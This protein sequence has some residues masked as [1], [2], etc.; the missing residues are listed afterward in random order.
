MENSEVKNSLDRLSQEIEKEFDTV[1]LRKM[2]AKKTSGLFRTIYPIE[3]SNLTGKENNVFGPSFP[4]LKS[5]NDN[6][7]TYACLVLVAVNDQGFIYNRNLQ[8][9]KSSFNDV[10]NFCSKDLGLKVYDGGQIK[11]SYAMSSG[12]DTNDIYSTSDTLISDDIYSKLGSVAYRRVLY[13]L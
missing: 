7:V 5:F 11:M 10:I 13:Y 2:F 8:T 6:D 1:I 4:K 12:M 9:N 3:S